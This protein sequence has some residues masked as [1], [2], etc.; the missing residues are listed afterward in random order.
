MDSHK[1]RLF[2]MN[3]FDWVAAETAEQANE[4]Y[5][6]EFGLSEEDQPIEDVME[7]PI[8]KIILTPYIIFYFL[9]FTH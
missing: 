2:R 4:W 9:P 8:D 5:I 1:V 6:K 7:E 3:D